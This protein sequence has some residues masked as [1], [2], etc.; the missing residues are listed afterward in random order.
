MSWQ[1]CALFILIMAGKPTPHAHIRFKKSMNRAGT[2]VRME[3]LVASMC[4]NIPFLGPAAP[5]KNRPNRAH[6]RSG[7]FVRGGEIQSVRPLPFPRLRVAP[8]W[9]RAQVREG[10]WHPP[11]GREGL[12][13]LDA[14]Y[15]CQPSPV[16]AHRSCPHAHS[17][18]FCAAPPC[19]DDRYL[20]WRF[21]Q[22]IRQRD[23]R[24][25]VQTFR[26]RTRCR[27]R[28]RTC[29]FVPLPLL[30]PPSIPRDC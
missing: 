10:M 22:N 21:R 19:R 9:V 5:P 29:P 27:Y 4:A 16:S 30:F 17:H 25:R 2:T 1:G 18:V 20:L 23:G 12:P 15:A 6:R 24:A 8:T 11:E 26:R 14:R 3:P 13:R 28:P 7:F